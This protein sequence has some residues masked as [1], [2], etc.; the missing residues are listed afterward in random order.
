MLVRVGV[1]VN[2]PVLVQM[3]QPSPRSYLKF[4]R[5]IPSFCTFCQQNSFRHESVMH[6][7]CD[8]KRENDNQKWF[9]L[10]NYNITY[11]YKKKL[12]NIDLGNIMF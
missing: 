5:F 9:P 12:S 7:F 11:L 1:A 8:L 3:L 4:I 2:K 10:F 6:S